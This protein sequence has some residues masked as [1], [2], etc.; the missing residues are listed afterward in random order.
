MNFFDLKNQ[1]DEKDLNVLH[2]IYLLRCLTVSQIYNNYYQDDYTGV[3]DFRNKKLHKLLDTGAIE[4]VL[5]SSDNSA[6]F[7]TRLGIDVVVNAFKIPINIVT[8]NGNVLRGYH[9]AHELKLQP[10]NIPHQVHLNQ[11][12]IDFKTIYE[13]KKLQI[14]WAYYDEKYVSQY[15]KIRP[16]GMISI[17][18]VDLFLEMDMSTESRVQLIDKWK[19]YKWFLNSVEHRNDRKVI[20]LFIIENTD[21]IENR[22]NLVKMTANEI[23]LNDMDD[24]FEI[25]VG[26]KEELLTIVFNQIIPDIQKTNYRKANI[27]NL[28]TSRHGFNVSDAS[29]LQN[30]LGKQDYGFFV[31]KLDESNNLLV[32]NGK[33]QGFLV[34]YCYRDTMSTIAKISYLDSNL[35]EFQYYYKWKPSYIIITDDL[36]HLYQDLK[37]FKLDRTNNVYFTTIKDL[38]SNIFPHALYQFDFTGDMYTFENS[39]LVHQQYI[40]KEE[41]SNKISKI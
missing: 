3:Q 2:N 11:F 21:L 34:D 10:K 24:T 5:F 33:I 9:R 6:I 39:G 41:I 13:Y 36:E 17:L 8:D 27:V 32:E 14:P 30:K 4:E 16:D 25:I 38:E 23:V 31:R 1:L 29:V 19:N 18:D 20:V 15:R 35:E 37:L 12:M 26:T 22:K 40:T 28:L 7:L